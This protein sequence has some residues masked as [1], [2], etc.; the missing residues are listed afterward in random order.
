MIKNNLNISAKISALLFLFTFLIPLCVFLA[1]LEVKYLLTFLIIILA[2]AGLI[3]IFFKPFFGILILFAM[4]PFKLEIPVGSTFISTNEF[5]VFYLLLVMIFQ[6]LFLGVKLPR[7]TKY[8]LLFMI[9]VFFIMFSIVQ[10]VN[11]E[12][13]V[14]GIFRYI[15]YLLMFTLIIRYADNIKKIK[16]LLITLIIVHILLSLYG[17]YQVKTIRVLAWFEVSVFRLKAVYDNPNNFAIVLEY[18]IPITI[19]LYW[20]GIIK[21]KLWA[22]LILGIF[23]LAIILTQTRTAWVAIALVLVY[24]FYKK[25]KTKVLIIVPTIIMILILLYPIYPDLVKQRI[26]T[27][28]DPNYSSNKGRI[29]LLKVT[30]N[31]FKD[32][33]LFGTGFGNSD[34]VFYKYRLPGI[35]GDIRDIHNMYMVIMVETG[36]LGG[37]VFLLFFIISYKDIMKIYKKIEIKE[38]RYMALGIGSG[39]LCVGIHLLNDHLFNDVRVEWLFWGMLGIITSFNHIVSYDKMFL[40]D[41]ET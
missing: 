32:N 8:H 26:E 36:I 22:Y 10:S 5:L 12:E 24:M 31:M 6:R 2:I 37:I 39:L 38:L 33:W 23:I 7:I 27:L 40:N 14:K 20:G 29:I 11:Q 13:T 3:I 19:G 41:V 16:A 15:G 17:F 4:F 1:L 35:P 9:F 30:Y 25:Y 34:D 21:K 18:L 28:T